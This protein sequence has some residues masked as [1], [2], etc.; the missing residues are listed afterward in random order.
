MHGAEFNVSKKGLLYLMVLDARIQIGSK[1]TPL[2]SR[3]GI[4]STK[5]NKLFISTNIFIIIL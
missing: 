3:H 4:R 5:G 1:R 2:V